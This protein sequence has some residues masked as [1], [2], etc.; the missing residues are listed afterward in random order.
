[1]A[2]FGLSLG[3]N[4]LQVVSLFVTKGTRYRDEEDLE[5]RMRGYRASSWAMFGASMVMVCAGVCVVG[6]SGIGKVGLKRE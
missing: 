3:I 5:T 2:Y 1:M 4:L 6:L